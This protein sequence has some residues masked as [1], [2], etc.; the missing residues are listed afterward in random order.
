MGR[1]ENDPTE[2]LDD[3]HP[4]LYR[5][6]LNPFGLNLP[7]LGDVL[8]NAT[9]YNFLLFLVSC[10]WTRISPVK[11]YRYRKKS[12]KHIATV[13]TCLLLFWSVSSSAAIY[14]FSCGTN[15]SVANC[16]LSEDYLSLEVLDTSL[17]ASFTL[18]NS[19]PLTSHLKKVWID[20]DAGIL[21]ISSSVK[22]Q[23]AGVNFQ[24]I[25]TSTR[26][27]GGLNFVAEGE[28]RKI[29]NTA[30]G[31]TSG[32][33][34]YEWLTYDF[35]LTGS[36]TFDLLIAALDAGTLSVGVHVGSYADGGSEKLGTSVSAVPVPAA[37]WLFGTGLLGLI[38]FSKHR[39]AA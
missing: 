23:S 19:G 22:T 14:N 33:L 36:N 25:S 9:G 35:V 8:L 38:G 21:D 4:T 24:N 2:T 30:N 12:M 18:T 32:V 1:P 28:A 37:I 16:N 17:G 39:K 6:I 31:V 15:N 27:I 26:N 5:A 13:F 3:C 10:R 7:N 20:D 34:L 29:G 11:P